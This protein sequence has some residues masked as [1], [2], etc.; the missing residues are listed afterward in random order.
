MPGMLT[1]IES[2][3]GDYSMN[4]SSNISNEFGLPD[5]IRLTRDGATLVV[6][7]ARPAKRNSLSDELVLG[8]SRRR[9]RPTWGRSCCMERA[10]ISAP[11][12]T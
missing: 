10:S 11:A 4:P 9:C 12:S 5:C 6:T 2:S 3:D 8:L 7:L 1:N